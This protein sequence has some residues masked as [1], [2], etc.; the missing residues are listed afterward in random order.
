M[1]TPHNEANLGQIAKTVLLPGDP[2][3]AKFLAETYLTDVKQFNH[4]RNMFGYTGMY[5]GKPVSIMGTGMGMPSLA[6]Y[7]LAQGACTDSNFAHQYKLPG[8]FSAIADFELLEK[9]KK[10]ADELGINAHVGNIFS[11]DVF[12]NA[13][14]SAEDWKRWA[15][16][17]CLCVE[18]ESYAL[19][20]LAAYYH[21]KALSILTI[22][23]SFITHK[24]TTHEERQVGLTRMIDIALKII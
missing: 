4:V 23:D 20:C 5:K 7:V 10:A 12:Y 14:V 16:M 11:S 1:P 18:M 21:K 19:Y 22:S 13:Y 3:R 9:A 6:I 2:L 15:D 24:E 17:G 8:T